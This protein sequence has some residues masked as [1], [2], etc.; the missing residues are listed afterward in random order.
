MAQKKLSGIE[1]FTNGY[2]HVVEQGRLS[3]TCRR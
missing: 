3:L 1:N 2:L